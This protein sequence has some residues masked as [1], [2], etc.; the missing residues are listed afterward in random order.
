MCWEK[1]HIHQTVLKHKHITKYLPVVHVLTGCDMASYRFGIGKATALNVL[2]GGHHLIELDQ[3]GRDE[4]KLT[5][6]ATTFLA[7]CYGSK[8]ETTDRYQMWKSK[9]VD[10]I[11]YGWHAGDDGTTP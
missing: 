5:Y 10:P 7:A 2:M 11:Q 1:D 9:I 3:H 8:V 4:D 6:Q